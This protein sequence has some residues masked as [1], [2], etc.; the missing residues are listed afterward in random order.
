M[1]ETSLDLRAQGR[2]AVGAGGLI[3]RD[4]E[5]AEID[6]FLAGPIPL[7]TLLGPGGVG[8]TAMAAEAVG[9]YQR[10]TGAAVYWV[11]LAK[12][13]A[14][15][16]SVA[17]LEE[18][19]R[20]VTEVDLTPGS[21]FD[22]VVGCLRRSCYASPKAR[23]VLVLD[24]CEHV[25]DGA[26]SLI[27]K[28]LAA[29]P[30]LVVL[31]TSREPIGWIDERLFVVPPLP[32]EMAVA[33]FSERA[34]LVGNAISSS[35]QLV[36]VGDICS[37]VHDNPLYICLAAARLRHQPLAVVLR[38]LSG[39]SG[40]RR[41]TWSHGPRLGA[42]TRHRAVFDVIAWSYERCD[43]EERVLLD[44]M[45]VF[46]AGCDVNPYT[47][48]PSSRLG[49]GVDLDAVTAVCSDGS[50]NI[51]A[52][53]N[54]EV[55]LTPPKIAAV[56]ERL[57]DRSLV[58]SRHTETAVYYSLSETIRVFAARQ[59]GGA[60]S[61]PTQRLLERHRDYYRNKIVAA[62][63]GWNGPQD[64]GYTEW[65]SS[66]WDNI[67]IAV[68]TCLV[69]PEGPELGLEICSGLV[70]LSTPFF[71]GAIRDVRRWLTRTLEASER[72]DE[73]S[74]SLQIQARAM[75][76]WLALCQGD[77]AFAEELLE[78]CMI[79]SEVAAGWRKRLAHEPHADLGFPAVVDFARGAALMVVRRDRRAVLVLGRARE[80]FAELGD[81]AG[82]SL[83][84]LVEALAA[85]L[86]GTRE[87]ALSVA[88]RHKARTARS[89][90]AW[91]ISWGEL[92][93]AVALSKHGDPR[94][95]LAVGKKAMRRLLS[96][97][98]RWGALWA[99]QVRAWALARIV[100]DLQA[101]GGPEDQIVA[102]A[103][104]IAN[105]TGAAAAAQSDLGLNQDIVGPLIDET[106][107]AA[108]I[109]RAVLGESGFTA[110]QRAG[111]RPRAGDRTPQKLTPPLGA[112]NDLES[113][114]H[115]HSDSAAARWRELTAAEKQVAILA[116]NGYTNVAIA[117]RRGSSAKTVDS[118]MTSVFQKLLI[119]T[120]RDIAPCIPAEQM[121]GIEEEQNQPS[122]RPTG[123]SHLDGA[124]DSP[125]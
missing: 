25:L 1:N 36:M 6:A 63:T 11:R 90:S 62:R 120:R 49:V 16:G 45:S 78:E 108:R 98:D 114:G 95:A 39:D 82:E 30:E 7:T 79:G 8:K 72:D 41:L 56:L 71:K 68:D 102:L 23:P 12:L 84:E 66:A 100:G 24:N 77:Y 97:G 106:A 122:P 17:V 67:A 111:S 35:K 34:Q 125:T 5:L 119:K 2:V 31:A 65:A 91:T 109:A 15:A 86:L 113:V 80:K 21:L 38:E 123:T 52:P 50:G 47:G 64:K 103:T 81:H 59:L 27:A 14:S 4:R 115:E 54:G 48:D 58:V 60:S 110:A 57:V 94:L 3:G 74:R 105:I 19:A 73:T 112:S 42:E 85:G 37:R 13:P 118:Q 28:V 10:A 92:A 51:V 26:G 40:D 61:L 87:A 117:A 22:A 75:A 89:M 44:R 18:V 69:T 124:S 121:G 43:A 55:I 99:A 70:A 93:W 46:A 53:P 83:S 104:E 20:S 107:H 88:A 29:V 76:S 33:L 32:R 101:N 116:A 96:I 9:R